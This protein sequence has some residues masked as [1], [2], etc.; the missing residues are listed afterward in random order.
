M[1]LDKILANDDSG[2]FPA[3]RRISDLLSWAVA[4]SFAVIG[5]GY[6][7]YHSR[8]QCKEQEKDELGIKAEQTGHTTIDTRL[9]E[10]R[11]LSGNEVNFGLWYIEG[12][13][14]RF[15]VCG[16]P[17]PRGVINVG[18]AQH[19][20]AIRKKYLA[21]AAP[22]ELPKN[23][24]KFLILSTTED[25]EHAAPQ[26]ELKK[27]VLLTIS[28][29]QVQDFGWYAERPFK[30]IYLKSSLESEKKEY[31]DYYLLIELTDGSVTKR[32]MQDSDAKKIMQKFG[33][34]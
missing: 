8:E 20:E 24:T 14:G 5:L 31:G 30:K 12:S 4:A 16:Q 21:A 7:L 11:G 6:L 33:Y 17:M 1:S 22:A 18:I 15:Y 3:P 34:E 13:D 2:R 19:G 10:N 25:E 26:A 27:T 28:P 32:D 23:K 29:K 9:A